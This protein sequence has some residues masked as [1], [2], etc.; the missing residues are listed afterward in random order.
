MP[1]EISKQEEFNLIQAAATES[2][3]T[4]V[5]R[6]KS[7]GFPGRRDESVDRLNNSDPED[8]DKSGLVKS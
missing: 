5:K 3:D 6:T 1:D 2:N 8:D 4:N 7:A